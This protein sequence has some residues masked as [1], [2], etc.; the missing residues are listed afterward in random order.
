VPGPAYYPELFRLCEAQNWR[1]C[2]CGITLATGRP[3]N[4]T[5]TMEHVVPKVAGGSN[6]WSNL[7]AACKLCNNA[8]SA[9]K[10]L[11]Y[12]RYV[13]WKGRETAARY[14]HRLRHKVQRRAFRSR[15]SS[16]ENG[17]SQS[18]GIWSAMLRSSVSRSI[19]THGR[20]T[21]SAGF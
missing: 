13:K 18:H 7:V 5:A 14:A 15:L 10:A 21:I 6:D 1:C 19:R 3:G 2:Y 20:I 12:L 16:H 11:K 4:D 17:T 8:R 9:M